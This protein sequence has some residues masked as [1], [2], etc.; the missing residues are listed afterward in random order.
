MDWSSFLLFVAE[1]QLRM[2]TFNTVQMANTSDCDNLTSCTNGTEFGQGPAVTGNPENSQVSDAESIVI[3]NAFLVAMLFVGVFGNI[4]TLVAIRTS[5]RLWTKSNTL[6]A[7]LAAMDFLVS[8]PFGLFNVSLRYFIDIFGVDLCKFNLI[9]AITFPIEKL[10][11][12]ASSAIVVSIAVDRYVAIVHCLRYDVLVTPFK[13]RVA[14][15]MSWVYAFVLCSFPLFYLVRRELIPCTYPFSPTLNNAVDMG[16]HFIL[17]TLL[18]VIYTRIFFI[19][20]KQQRRIHVQSIEIHPS[21]N[22]HEPTAQDAEGIETRRKNRKRWI[23]E[24]RALRMTTALAVTYSLL[25]VP[26]FIYAAVQTSSE[27]WANVG[28]FYATTTLAA[29]N[30]TFQWLLYAITSK[31]YMRAYTRI[32][33]CGARCTAPRNSVRVTQ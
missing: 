5:P 12:F 15:G 19:T 27:L 3:I 29:L 7:S 30:T 6:I 25:P 21:R 16:N 23:K 8:G 33:T 11:Y 32:L 26:Y 14:I 22:D 2:D 24:W 31:E 1:F 13:I 10:P 18:F 28:A 4:L 17:S 20:I 9:N